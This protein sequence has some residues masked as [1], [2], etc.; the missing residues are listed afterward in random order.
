AGTRAILDKELLL[1]RV[2]EMLRQH[3][4]DYVGPTTRRGRHDDAHGMRGI[5]VIVLWF[6]LWLSLGGLFGLVF[7]CIAL[8]GLGIG[9]PDLSANAEE[10]QQDVS[11]HAHGL[12]LEYT[13]SQTR[14]F[15]REHSEESM[16]SHGRTSG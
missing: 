10:Q 8:I 2:G 12:Q 13:P 4:C 7:L 1:E 11:Q 14:E 5:N 16:A 15:D 9:L 3:A 6:S